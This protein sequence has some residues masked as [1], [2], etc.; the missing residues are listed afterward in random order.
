M[1]I[2][3][4]IL[5]SAGSVSSVVYFAESASKNIGSHTNGTGLTLSA[6]TLCKIL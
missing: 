5:A 1:Y 6:G 3:K 2:G 4:T